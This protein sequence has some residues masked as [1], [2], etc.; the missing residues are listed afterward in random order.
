MSIW[1]SI[2]SMHMER[3]QFTVTIWAILHFVPNQIAFFAHKASTKPCFCTMDSCCTIFQSIFEMYTQLKLFNDLWGFFPH[4]C[5]PSQIFFGGGGNDGDY[6]YLGCMFSLTSCANV[7]VFRNATM[8][9]ALSLSG[10]QTT[11]LVQQ[12]QRTSSGHIIRPL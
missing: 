6:L 8:Q 5:F 9:T 7:Q 4:E 11:Y 12:P 2:C 1:L 10:T 3:E